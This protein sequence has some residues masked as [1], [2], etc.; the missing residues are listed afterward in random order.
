M[1]I[2]NDRLSAQGDYFD[3]R[4]CINAEVLVSVW[5]WNSL[6]MK[7]KEKENTILGKVD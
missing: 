2:F 7:M 4:D 1:K 5:T 3:E 6:K